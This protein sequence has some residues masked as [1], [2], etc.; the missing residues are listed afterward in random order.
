MHICYLATDPPLT[1]Q[2]NL[3][4]IMTFLNLQLK[5]TLSHKESQVEFDPDQDLVQYP[6]LKR[7]HN[8]LHSHQKMWY[9][10]L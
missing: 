7:N 9:Y 1:L 8:I 5:V 4:R 2:V 3:K 6:P 10:A